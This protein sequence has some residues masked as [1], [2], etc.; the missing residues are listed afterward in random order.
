MAWDLFHISLNFDV[1]GVMKNICI[2]HNSLNFGGTDTFVI[3]LCKG[4]IKDGYAVTVILSL[5]KSV[6]GPRLS[7]LEATGA[8]ILYTCALK[9]LGSKIKHLYLLFQALRTRKYD[10]FQ[11]NIDLFNGPNML[12]AW[13]AGVPIRECHSHNSQQGRELQLGKTVPVRLYQYFMRFLCWSFSNRRGACSEE[14]MDFLFKRKWVEDKSSKVIHNGI[15]L[16]AFR[17]TFDVI[18]KKKE[19]GL[20][21]RFNI[22]TVGRISYQKNPIFIVEVLNELF[23]L[24][25]DCDFVWVGIGDMEAQVYERIAYY[26][27][28]ERIHMLG[29]RSDVAEILRSVDVFFL[30][31]NF[32]GLGIVLIEAQAADLP[33]VTATT[34][35]L[36]ANCGSV[37]YL[38]L[39]DSPSK[40]AKVLSD[41]LDKRIELNVEYEKLEKFSI[42]NMVYEMESLFEDE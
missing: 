32:E 9:S 28:E 20:N 38:S 26:G 30:P 1:D 42:E 14:A 16:S 22:C 29:A 31:S 39:E 37:L 21:N 3:N 34:T 12:I 19:L 17:K 6:A 13:L 27:I 25:D 5:D 18:Q 15:D 35:P 33:C 24:R 41:I 36:E 23:K 2:L 8:N 4:L 10:V 40:W 7:D 11:A